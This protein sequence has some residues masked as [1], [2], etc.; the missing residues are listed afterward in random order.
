MSDPYSYACQ[1]D[2]RF[3]NSRQ[4][5]QAVRVLQVDKEPGD[6]VTKSF[7][8]VCSEGNDT[9]NVKDVLRM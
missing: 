6:R 8:I 4:A 7:S 2:V 1:I 3:P 5:E 9:H